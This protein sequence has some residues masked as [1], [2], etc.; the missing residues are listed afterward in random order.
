MKRAILFLCL[1]LLAALT[2]CGTGGSG[3]SPSLASRAAEQ[4]RTLNERFGQTSGGTPEGIMRDAE[5]NLVVTTNRRSVFDSERENATF[6]GTNR[7]T[8]QQFAAS[9]FATRSWQGDRESNAGSAYAGSTDGS[10][11][12]GSRSSGATTASQQ[13]QGFAT[14]G[15]ATSGYST[16]Q[17]REEGRPGIARQTDAATE[18]RREIQA[19]PEVIDWREQRSMDLRQVRSI[20]GRR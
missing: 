2:A 16:G 7:S 8:N 19:Q 15:I 18:R 1:P 5:G 9:Q 12:Q 3:D 17:A 20:L 6:R 4:T 14:R 13:G 11:F 10:R